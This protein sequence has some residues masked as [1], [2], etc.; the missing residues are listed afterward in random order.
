MTPPPEVTDDRLVLRGGI[1]CDPD[2]RREERWSA[3]AAVDPIHAALATSGVDAERDKSRRDIEYLLE[4]AQGG[5]LLDLGCG[6]GRVA[7]YLLLRR[8]FDCYIG[9]DGSSTMLQ[10]FRDRYDTSAL[11]QRTPLLLVQSAIDDVKLPD[12]SVDTVVIAAVLLHNPKPVTRA[13]L[14]EAH[15]VLRPGGRILVLNDLPNSRTPAAVPN[16]LYV[17]A[18]EVIGRGDRNGPV[19][20]YSRAEVDALFAA[21][22]D[23]QV[24][25]TGRAVLP[26]RIPGAPPSVSRRYR[27]RVHDPV[28][29]WAEQRLPASW[30]DRL[31][32]NVCVSATR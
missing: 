31:Y 29:R 17:L 16:R 12:A 21:F 27:T 32:F 25:P 26:K 8:V 18:L 4:H 19:R 9:I 1:W 20:T 7:K 23:V 24:R 5:I 13:V 6:Y 10:L 14:R 2:D 22:D 15:R 28:Q 30:L 11:E 3:D